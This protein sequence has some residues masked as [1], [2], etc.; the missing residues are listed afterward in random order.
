MVSWVIEGKGGD[1]ATVADV[2][3]A[4]RALHRAVLALYSRT[5]PTALAGVLE[6]VVAPLR[7]AMVTEGARALQRG[8]TWSVQ[9][10]G[11]IITLAP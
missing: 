4:A 7:L 9:H 3:A 5:D 6:R 10:A 11:I 2:E 1:S 8:E